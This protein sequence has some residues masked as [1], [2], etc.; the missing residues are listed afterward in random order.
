MTVESPIDRVNDSS[1]SANVGITKCKA[2]RHV[3][4][5]ELSFLLR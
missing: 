3:D 5:L 1:L 4:I 2:Q